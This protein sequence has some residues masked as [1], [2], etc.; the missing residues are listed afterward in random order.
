MTEE[1]GTERFGDVTFTSASSR[2]AFLQAGAMA[3][4]AM[5]IMLWQT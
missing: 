3:I 2:R 5:F 4:A 1:F